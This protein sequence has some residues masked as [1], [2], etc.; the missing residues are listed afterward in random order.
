M[1]IK[2][3]EL[4]TIPTFKN[5]KLLAGE[6]GLDRLV[7]W[8]HILTTPYLDGW[9]HGGEL[10]F[11]THSEDI[12]KVLKDA[13]VHQIAGVVILRSKENKSFINDEMIDFA[14]K[15]NLPLFEMDYNIK[16]VDITRDISAYIMQKQEKIDYLDYFFHNI[17]FSQDLEKKNIDEF[18]LHYGLRSEHILFISTI[19]S[20]DSSKLNDVQTTMERYI[21]DTDVHFLMMKIN[22]YLVILA[23]TTP[24][25]VQK[26]KTLLKSAFSVLNESFPDILF[27]GIGNTCDSL[28]DIRNSYKKSMKSIDLCREKTRIID[29]A[30][31]GFPRLLFNTREEELEDY[32]R[33]ILGDV[34]EYD[35][36]NESAFLETIETYILCNGNISQTSSKL[37][38]H[39][40]TCIYRIGRINELFQLDL[41]DPYT[42]AEILNCLYIYRYLGQIK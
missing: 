39:R 33:Y 32:A 19:H 35:E 41:D 23:Y 6:S 30:E 42:R 2:C 7:S 22:S 36:E 12:Y 34:K 5:I 26:A 21:E 31:L 13:I 28:Y 17:L 10:I 8:V 24:D 18:T 15:E 9:V 11:I 16:L 40:N 14:N 27:M 29:Y 3:Y 1:Y 20:K 4:M 38:I 37:Y 25:F